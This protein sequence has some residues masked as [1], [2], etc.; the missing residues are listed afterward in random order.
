MGK[1]ELKD[2]LTKDKQ[3]KITVGDKDIAKYYLVEDVHKSIKILC[4]RFNYLW[5]DGEK[6]P[7]RPS[8]EK[9]MEGIFDEIENC[10]PVVYEG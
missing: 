1:I 7:W 9:D 4:H 8:T 5:R 3:K 6:E 2:A 10:F